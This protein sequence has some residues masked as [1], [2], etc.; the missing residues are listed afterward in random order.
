[1]DVTNRYAST[2]MI[3]A[4]AQAR[5]P[6]CSGIAINPRLILTAASCVCSSAP[7]AS[8]HAVCAKRSFVATVIYGEVGSMDFKEATTGKRYH[9]Y[10][11]EVRLHPDFMAAHEVQGSTQRS[12]ADLA[13]I[14]LD[15][16]IEEA[17][18][19][20]P[21]A[22]A[23]LQADEFLIMSGYARPEPFGGVPGGIRYFRRNK[24]VTVL[25][26]PPGKALY[27][28]QGVFVYNGFT[29]GP[30]IREEGTRRWLVGIASPGSDEELPLTSV[31]A[32]RDWLLAEIRHAADAATLPPSTPRR[33]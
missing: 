19:Y 23:E 2:V 8:G 26:S 24:V 21:L 6:T 7:E 16:P 17:L 14:L 25:Q 9:A 3:T 18:E 1:M 10:E 27:E 15:K 33:K 12:H 13:V 11:G 30:C 20:V 32:F 31:Y 29:G 4:D 28:Q 22:R 5:V